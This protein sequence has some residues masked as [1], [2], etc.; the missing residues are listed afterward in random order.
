MTSLEI[1]SP[2]FLTNDLPTPPNNGYF[3]VSTSIRKLTEEKGNTITR[4]LA[5]HIHS[6]QI[7][8]L[9]GV[10]LHLV[11]HVHENCQAN[12]GIYKIFSKHLPEPDG[13]DL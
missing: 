2:Y 9:T 7:A 4:M 10:S 8:L 12:G 6:E 1:F 3:P 13:H 5:L 11:Y